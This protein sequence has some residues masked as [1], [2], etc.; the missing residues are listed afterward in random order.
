MSNIHLPNFQTPHCHLQS[1]DT[2]TTLDEFVRREVELQT[3]T[4]TCTDHGYLGAIREAYGL[5][6]ENK[7]TLIPG[8]EGY[9]RDDSCP[10]FESNG[11]PKDEDGTYT[12]NYKYGHITIHALDQK[13]Y[14]LLVK[15]VSDR[16][17]T[18]E[19]HG[20]ERK[21]IFDWKDLE[22]ICSSNVTY[23]S[24]CLI[25]VIGRL[26]KEGQI[27]LA[28]AYYE[29]LRSFNP[30]N[31][32]VELFT[33][34]CNKNWV[35]GVFLTLE[36]G[37]TKK[38]YLGKK[39][40]TEEFEEI[41]V[42]DLAKAVSKGKNVG[43]LLGIK[44]NRT[45][46]L[47]E[48]KAIVSCNLIQDFIEN[49]CTAW[50]PDGDIQKA[51]NLYLMEKAAK[52]G[53]KC[54]ISDDSHYAFKEEKLIQEAKLGGMGDSFRFYGD[55]HRYSS[56]EAFVHFNE[57]LGFDEVGFRKLIDNN[58]EWSNR[59]KSF[60]LK[61][62][63]SLPTKFYPKDSLSHLMKLIE[64]KGRMDWNNEAMKARLKSEIELLHNNGTV[65]L[66]PYFF[67]SE[68]GIRVH[69][70]AG[71]L[72]GVGR[73]SS[74]GLLTAYLLGITHAD[75][76]KHNLSQDRFLTADRIKTG[77]LPD[78]DQDLPNR[79]ILL[80]WLKSRFGD[81]A[82]QV[83]T[84]GL[85]HLK[86]S[87]LNVARATWGRVP[88]DIERLTKSLPSTPQG[89]EDID[90]INGYVSED[91]KE[92]R[93]LLS[94]HE[95]LKN[96]TK[97]HPDLWKIVL[98]LCGVMRSKGRHPSAYIVA[99]RPI[100]SFIP[101]MTIGGF[102]ATQY[103]HKACEESGA[104]KMDYLSLNTLIDIQAALSLIQ[105][106]NKNKLTE[107]SYILNGKKVPA[108]R[109]LHFNNKM[110]DIWDLPEK[111]EVFNSIADGNTETV[112]Q[113]NT[114]SAQKW[115]KEFNYWTDN[116]Q[117]RK[118]INSIES[119][120]AFT[121]LDRPGPLDA[122][123]TDGNV[124]RNM[125]QEYAARARG[126]DPLDEIPVLTKELPETFGVMVYQEQLQYIY[127]KLTDS[128]GIEANK[129]R[130][131]VSK[132]RIPK[133]NERYPLF[134]E[135]ASAKIGAQDAQKI[136]DQIV[137]FGSYGFNKSHG[138]SYSYIAYAC[139]FIK[140]YY[141]LEWWCGVLQNAKKDEI[142]SKFW[143][144]CKHIVNLPE[145]SLSEDNFCIKEEKIQAPIS[146]LIGVGPKAQEELTKNKPYTSLTDFAEKIYLEKKKKATI[147]KDKSKLGSSSLNR[148]V[149]S[150]LVISG[151]MDSFFNRNQDV[152]AKLEQFE[153]VY[154]NIIKKKPQKIKEEYRNITPI[155]V[156][157]YKKQILPIFTDNL[158]KY[159]FDIHVDGI[160][161][162]SK[163]IGD[164]EVDVYTYQPKNEETIAFIKK[165]FGKREL[166][167]KLVF[168]DGD[169]LHYMD[170]EAIVDPDEPLYV[171][172][173]AYVSNAIPFNFVN[174][175][176]QK[177]SRAVKYLLDIN[178]DTVEFVHWANKDGELFVP[179][180]PVIGSIVIAILNKWNERGFSI[181]TLIKV[182][183][184]LGE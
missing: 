16:D 49:E 53:D 159:L 173:A 81:H 41:S 104:I 60:E 181:K 3:G 95:G 163:Q 57:T 98:K 89:V 42:S 115:M 116:T 167:G 182:V 85:L 176:T 168:V 76:L 5:A 79:D 130:E 61:N 58:Q 175:K 136:W 23:T 121:S 161:K 126:E 19:Q 20:S 73:G 66:L 65:D 7:L 111:T 134:M 103:T 4:L 147:K 40:R 97:A 26:F 2:A 37:E 102:R 92:V 28:N 135:K 39:V 80:P 83:S 46:D 120:S 96:F 30:K 50:N 183:E 51:L 48:P 125:L 71:V 170:K 84:N 146:M 64:E 138:I 152:I 75:P 1:L 129:F 99:N 177:M 151:V 54:L 127:Q 52:Y 25:G 86:S 184:P 18:A 22:E 93:G 9:F 155:K 140:Y 110:Y 143:K 43:K 128:T 67:L 13:S 29:K 179:E 44:N 108:F 180:N 70:E 171:A 74:A 88:D 14:E 87:I 24:G 162:K 47:F 145:I 34:K 131:D 35:S 56:D 133:I 10:I 91:G 17:L 69:E 12:K 144:Y 160:D 59:F 90:F 77:K 27:E 45:W 150:K 105:S 36:G 114:A 148:G 15:K 33:H 113:L 123:I 166:T 68:E 165:S 100:D 21:P 154:S 63:I 55:Y 141:P 157:Q 139:A 94:T 11:F 109:I 153:A 82:A 8:I 101:M 31:F 38:Y 106:R 122:V 112:F 72:T 149:V 107:K 178:G 156:Y 119:I 158:A 172:V 142:A 174:K 117:E 137:T 6:K 78:I 124:S 62:E 118:T 132:K 164:K 32:Y 169:L